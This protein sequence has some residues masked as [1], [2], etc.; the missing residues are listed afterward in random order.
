MATPQDM[1][2]TTLEK[3]K[4]Q[5]SDE[6]LLD[7]RIFVSK[8]Y[9]FETWG[10]WWGLSQRS[11]NVSLQMDHRHVQGTLLCLGT[12]Q[13]SVV[14]HLD[15][16]QYTVA[17]KMVSFKCPHDEID[18]VETEIRLEGVILSTIERECANLDC[19][20]HIGMFF[21][22]NDVMPWKAPMLILESYRNYS[23]LNALFVNSFNL[24]DD[25]WLEMMR[26]ALF[27]ILFTL[28]ELQAVFPGFRHNDLKDNNILVLLLK[29]EEVYGSTYMLHN[30]P[31]RFI[32]NSVHIDVK[33]IDFA[34]AH[35]EAPG[36]SNP[37]VTHDVYAESE[38]SASAC[39]LYDLHFLFECF[40]LRLN[41]AVITPAMDQVL[42]FIRDVIPYKYF[43]A[44]LMNGGKRLSGEGQRAINSDAA[45][46]FKSPA[47]ALRHPFFG[48][49]C[50]LQEDEHMDGVE[51][52]EMVSDLG[53]EVEVVM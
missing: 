37:N 17:L 46:R 36:V 52:E 47:D 4:R 1:T 6:G 33:I 11:G 22:G 21:Y 43:H 12:G 39:P 25:V 30:S 41:G 20:Q 34:T 29:P 42:Q 31:F 13:H 9:E 40:F 14:M 19:K 51:A 45:L 3:V 5:L 27:Q 35:A 38:I 18:F 7:F 28:A 8:L 48:S 23:E 44:G 16:P 49:F 53:L 15:T 24:A 10:E 26:Q 50:V 32:L 2:T